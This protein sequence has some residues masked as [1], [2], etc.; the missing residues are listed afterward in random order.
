M[1]EK[2]LRIPNYAC[3]I[4][5]F[6]LCLYSSKHTFNTFY[7]LFQYPWLLIFALFISMC[8]Y[9]FEVGM[10]AYLAY[11]YIFVSKNYI[12]GGLTALCIFTAG[13]SMSI[14]SVNKWLSYEHKCCSNC[15]AMMLRYISALLLITPIA[16]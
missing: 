13:I 10:D 16:W 5:T 1:A 14:Y 8:L 9:M 6:T 7:F 15:F 4:T 2:L 3:K 11:S 12:W